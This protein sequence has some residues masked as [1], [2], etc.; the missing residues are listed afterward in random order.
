MDRIFRMTPTNEDIA[1]LIRVLTE[2]G[3][4]ERSSMDGNSGNI[5]FTELGQERMKTLAELI[6]VFSTTMRDLQMPASF[7]PILFG[8]VTSWKNDV[9][10]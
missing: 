8:F 7:L 1:K 3:W 6:P 10:S 9:A 5:V 4:I 2:A